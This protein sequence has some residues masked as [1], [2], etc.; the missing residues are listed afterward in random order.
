MG[1]VLW[2]TEPSTVRVWGCG[3]KAGLGQ[4]APPAGP[5]TQPLAQSVLEAVDLELAAW[6]S[7]QG[8]GSPG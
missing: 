1:S 6:A 4:G 2:A 7:A 3:P 5:S 8:G